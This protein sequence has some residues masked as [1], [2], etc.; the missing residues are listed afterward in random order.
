VIFNK[1]YQAI[2]ENYGSIKTVNR[3]FYPR[4]FNLSLEF[5]SAF[6]KEFCRLQSIGIDKKRILSKMNKALHFH[7]R[8]SAKD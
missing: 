8:D 6:K 3:I 4:N 7:C 2:L 1:K 5:V